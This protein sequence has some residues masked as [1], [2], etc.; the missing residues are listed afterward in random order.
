L[1]QCWKHQK[2]AKIN[3]KKTP[4]KGTLLMVGA[5]RIILVERGFFDE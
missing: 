5:M 2:Q 4:I 3:A 1:K